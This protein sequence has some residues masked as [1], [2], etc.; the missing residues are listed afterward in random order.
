MKI[1]ACTVPLSQHTANVHNWLSSALEA[2][3]VSHSSHCGINKQ[4][5]I[6]NE[7]HLTY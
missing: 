1:C 7:S 2:A 6:H 3:A 4:L 5:K